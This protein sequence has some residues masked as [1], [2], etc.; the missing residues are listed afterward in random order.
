MSPSVAF[1]CLLWR[2]KNSVWLSRT[3]FKKGFLAFLPDNPDKDER[4]S[5]DKLGRK[6]N[7]KVDKYQNLVTNV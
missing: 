7:E 2:F 5:K 1:D 4:K 3:I 6:G